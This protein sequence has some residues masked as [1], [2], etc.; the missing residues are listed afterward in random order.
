MYTQLQLSNITLVI[1][2]YF[3]LT[4]CLCLYLMKKVL[5][6]YYYS[7]HLEIDFK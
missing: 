2:L 7:I 5:F 1:L 4:T 6:S 3:S